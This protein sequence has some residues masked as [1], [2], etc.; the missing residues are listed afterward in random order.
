MSNEKM[1]E[2]KGVSETAFIITVVILVAMIGFVV[3]I[4]SNEY[5]VLLSNY[6]NFSTSKNSSV[7][8]PLTTYTIVVSAQTDNDPFPRFASVSIDQ[9]LIYKEVSDGTSQYSWIVSGNT[10]R[11]I[12]V[13]LPAGYHMA[14][15]TVS[16]EGG[17]YW[18][19]N[20]TVNGQTFNF[21]FSAVHLCS[22]DIIAMPLQ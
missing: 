7:T 12:T 17:Y 1:N 4:M 3:L 20:L 19:G 22:N 10:T 16:A 18:T 14:Y 6:S 13:D 15:F 5:N 21:N 9:P 2:K 8:G 11:T